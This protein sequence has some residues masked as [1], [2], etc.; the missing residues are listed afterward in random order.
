[1]FR[2][3]LVWGSRIA[4]FAKRNSRNSGRNSGQL[5]S[6]DF[7]KLLSWKIDE[8]CESRRELHPNAASKGATLS[9][10]FDVEPSHLVAGCA[11]SHD[12]GLDV[13]NQ[14]TFFG[15]KCL[16]MVMFHQ[17]AHWNTKAIEKTT[18]QHPEM[19]D[20]KMW[21]DCMFVCMYVRTYV[22]VYVCL[23]MSM[24]V[25]VY[26]CLCLC[27]CMSM[28]MS[29]SMYVYVYVCLCMSMYVYVCLCMSMYVYVYVCLCICLCLCLCMC[30]Y[31]YI[32][33]Y[34]YVC[35]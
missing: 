19:L 5:I 26:V 23:C 24:Y 35:V 31:L 29:M 30:M 15:L 8:N 25:Y 32:Y 2:N 20:K 16:R 11:A 21:S 6:N 3:F 10:F 27:L 12:A 34:I 14:T 18:V 33:I 7:P 28:S 22:R 4:F 17:K 9:S 13:P 1:M